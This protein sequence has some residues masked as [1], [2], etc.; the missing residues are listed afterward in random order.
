MRTYALLKISRVLDGH[1]RR[2]GLDTFY[3]GGSESE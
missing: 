3:R 2:N 1:G